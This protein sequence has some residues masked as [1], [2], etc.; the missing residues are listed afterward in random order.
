MTESQNARASTPQ[1]SPG[2]KSGRKPAVWS[3]GDDTA[4]NMTPMIDIVFQLII[5]FLLSLKFKSVDQ[6]IDANMPKDRG[7]NAIPIQVVNH[8]KIKIKLFR[9]NR[10]NPATAYTLVKIDGSHTFRMPAGEWSKDKG[11][12][13]ARVAEYDAAM[14]GVQQ[15]I[16]A[17]WSFLERDPETRAEIVAPPPFGM[18]VPHGDVIRI[19]DT[20]VAAGLTKVHFEGV[21]SPLKP[22]MSP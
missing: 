8:P 3:T 9:K 19:L 21:R 7:P 6:R 22:S 1:G 14:A 10:E 2:S 12:D 15:V 17:K 20:F 11:Y 5:F 4:M 18:S 16:E 13:A